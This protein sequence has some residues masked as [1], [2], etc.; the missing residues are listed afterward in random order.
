MSKLKI[1]S[2]QKMSWIKVILLA[3]ASAVLTAVLKLIPA[4]ENTSFQDIAVNPECW[5]LFAVF[6]IVN[7]KKPLEAVLK[8]F[9][10]F[11][12]SQPLIYLIQVPFSAQGFG[13][14][15]YYK[16]WFFITLL[17]LPGAA[18]AY[19]VKRRDWLGAAVLSVAAGG[20]GY[21]AADYFWRVKA[22]FPHHLLSLCFCIALALFLTF[23]LLDKKTHRIA[24]IGVTAAVMAITL[25]VTKPTVEQTV[26]LE[27]GTWSY[28]LDHP[29]IADIKIEEGNSVVV[30]AKSK[31]TAVVTFTNEQGK[32]IEYCVTVSGGSVY[33]NAIE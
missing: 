9:V 8:T 28:V 13:I 22:D 21:M 16:Y 15:Q 32:T 11:L 19:L 25:F 20:L 29:E 31:G 17:T 24:V 5:L 3:A 2:E 7:C 27:D 1:F 23:A 14:F 33:V 12:I 6:I 4:L 10:F 18:I 26:T 30:T